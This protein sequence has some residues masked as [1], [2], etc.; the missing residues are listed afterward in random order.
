MAMVW[1]LK[2]AMTRKTSKAFIF[3]LKSIENKTVDSVCT[4]KVVE[5]AIL[6]Q[7]AAFSQELL[8][9]VDSWSPRD[10]VFAHAACCNGKSVENESDARGARGKVK[11]SA[12]MNGSTVFGWTVS[13]TK[14]NDDRTSNKR[15]N[16]HVN[17]QKEEKLITKKRDRATHRT[18]ERGTKHNLIYSRPIKLASSFGHFAYGTCWT[19]K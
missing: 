10:R 5:A 1:T 18:N 9:S 3:A 4:Q 7:R 19:T 16:T 14:V 13:D 2:S 15:V 12:E 8:L 11:K 6:K 17:T